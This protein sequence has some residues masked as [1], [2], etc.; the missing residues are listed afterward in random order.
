MLSIQDLDIKGKTVFLRCDIN[1]PID[2]DSLKIL[3]DSRLLEVAETID[4]LKDSK[5]IV[6][7]HQG[8]VGKSDYVSMEQHA[9]VLSKLLNRKID[10]VPDVFGPTAINTIKNL[11]TG[12]ILLLDNLRFTAEENAEML[13]KDAIK[14]HL[15]SKLAEHIDYCVLDAFSTSHRS[16]PSIVGFAEL[17]PA[18]AGKIVEREVNALKGIVEDSNIKFT[19]ILGGA[20]IPD[21]LKS[22]QKLI[23]AGRIEKVLLGG[24]IGNVF[25]A[26]TEKVPLEAT[27]I[28]DEKSINTAKSLLEKYPEKFMLADDVAVEVDGKRTEKSLSEL[29]S[30]DRI[31]DIGQKT[32]NKYSQ[33]IDNAENIFITGPLGMFENSEFRLGTTEILTKLSNTNARTITSGGHLSAVLSQLDLKDKIYHVSTAGGA[34]IRYLTGEELPLLNALN[35]SANKHI[36]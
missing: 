25:L 23:E 27:S 30:S 24:L 13:P 19:A 15:V 5:L 6:A 8:R 10:F 20:K 11:K 4:A 12:D 3:D 36:K 31:F 28:D 26:A 35:N 29:D 14:S 21:R 7:S 2:P 17:R 18:C 22:I 34:L 32:I 9:P 1:S 16:H 33:Q